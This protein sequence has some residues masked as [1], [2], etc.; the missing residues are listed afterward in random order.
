MVGWFSR[1]RLTLALAEDLGGVPRNLGG[2]WGWDQLVPRTPAGGATRK[3][4]NGDGGGVGGRSRA[5]APAGGLVGRE[6][7]EEG[8]ARGRDG[9]IDRRR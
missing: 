9:G 1:I 4:G 2:Q 5:R 6:R 3:K 8:R 7:V